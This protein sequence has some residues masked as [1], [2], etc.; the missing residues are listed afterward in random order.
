MM[1]KHNHSHKTNAH[2]WHQIAISFSMI[3]RKY[4]I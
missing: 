3:T 4:L 1:I 2:M